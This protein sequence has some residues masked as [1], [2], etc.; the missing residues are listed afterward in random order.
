MTDQI[1]P[2]AEPADLPTALTELR[3]A[4]AEV[5]RLRP[6]VDMVDQAQ[7]DAERLEPAPGDWPS[8]RAGLRDE[9][10]EALADSVMPVL[11]RAW[12]WL[13]A[14]AETAPEPDPLPVTTCARTDRHG[15]HMWP[16]QSGK[17][18]FC[19]SHPAPASGR[20][21]TEATEADGDPDTRCGDPYR[22]E[23][24]GVARCSRGLGHAGI[25]AG[26]ADDG[27]TFQWQPDDTEPPCC[28]DPT[29]TCVQVN[30]AG[31]CD[32]THWEADTDA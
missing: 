25:H 7:R 9:I 13:R 8:R 24:H 10:A 3:H 16:Q 32:C 18:A 1:A 28:S 6:F 19:P 29:C 27:T 21:A 2:D 11:Y 5:A 4:R 26:H 30:A 14:E 12:P 22:T 17:P 20:A 23:H 31:R 15:Y